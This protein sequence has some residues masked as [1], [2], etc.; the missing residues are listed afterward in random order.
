MKPKKILFFSIAL[1]IAIILG[2]V[3]ILFSAKKKFEPKEKY[4]EFPFSLTYSIDG[5]IVTIDGTYVC[6]FDGIGWD[7]GR[8]YYRKWIGYV[9]ET[10]LENVLIIEDSD[11]QIFCQVGDP[12][13][14]MENSEGLS[15]AVESLS[16][17]HLYSVKKS[18][19]FDD[20]LVEEI[21]QHY[22][23]EIISWDFSQPLPQK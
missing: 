20:M 16:P 1:I 3:I 6:E 15:W 10:G 7:T 5:E 19:G 23:I 17:P 22:K 2:G 12:R 14:Y 9:K 8:G 13:Y 4:A 11:R 21:K 18:D